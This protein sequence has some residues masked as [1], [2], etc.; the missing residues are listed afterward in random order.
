MSLVVE[1]CVKLEATTVYVVAWLVALLLGWQM[2]TNVAGLVSKV[3][4]QKERCK[5]KVEVI[6]REEVFSASRK[7]ILLTFCVS[8]DF[9]GNVR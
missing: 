6:R 2:C 4:S 8:L 1:R 7:F 3:S 9:V 5:S